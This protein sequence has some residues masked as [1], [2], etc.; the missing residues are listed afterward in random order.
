MRLGRL[1][2]MCGETGNR[3]Q[4]EFSGHGM[5]LALPHAHRDSYSRMKLILKYKY[6]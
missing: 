5:D 6:T 4:L 1:G 2:W 3:G